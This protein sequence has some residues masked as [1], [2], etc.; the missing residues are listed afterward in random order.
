MPDSE[1]VLVARALIV[2]HG[3]DAGTAAERAL[4][5][6]RRP[7]LVERAQWWERVAHAIKE[8]E[9]GTRRQG[10]VRPPGGGAQRRTSLPSLRRHRARRRAPHLMRAATS[11]P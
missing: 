4:T 7:G 10:R 5:N 6:V 8:I 9:A 2:A 11:S 3:G 1:I